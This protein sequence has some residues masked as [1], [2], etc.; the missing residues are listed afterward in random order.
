M[1]ARL[2]LV[3]LDGIPLVKPGDDLAGIIGDALGR[4]GETL[5]DGDVLVVAQKIVSKAEGRFVD[6]DTVTPSAEAEE[7]AD[8]VEKDPRVVE[9]ILR[10]SRRVVRK[11]PGLLIVEDR[12]GLVLAN[13]GI[14]HSNVESPDGEETVLL[15][16]EDPDHSAST[17]RRRLES[18]SGASLGVVVAD[19]LGR[20][21]RLG[22]VGVAIGSSGLPALL[23]LRGQPDLE[24]RRLEVT[25]VGHADQLA[26]AASLLMGQAAEGLPAVLVRG[27]ASPSRDLPATALLRPPEQDLFR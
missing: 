27:L 10:E 7:L 25:E 20:P 3:V 18:A 15:L 22:T 5:Q 1:S 17:L 23:D 11:R 21:W 26:S 14:D 16:P 9:L 2:T 24:G 19:S 6:L 8:A 12:R 13:A 4:N